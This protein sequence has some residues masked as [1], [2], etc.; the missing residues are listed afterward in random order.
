MGN[1]KAMQRPR[2]N[3]VT[4]TVYDNQKNE[5]LILGITLQKQHDRNPLLTGPLRLYAT[6]YMPMPLRAPISQDLKPHYYKPDLDN[7]LKML[8]DISNSIIFKD[9]CLICEMHAKK[10]YSVNP[11]TE[12]YFEE[13]NVKKDK[14]KIFSF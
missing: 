6:F 2:F 12:F 14:D 9:D 5:R 8:C 4:R 7:L 10:L 1:P 3:A 13:I 11:R